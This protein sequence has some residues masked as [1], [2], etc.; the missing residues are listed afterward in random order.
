MLLN[1]LNQ[2]A[3]EW[4]TR[5]GACFPLPFLVL[6]PLFLMLSCYYYVPYLFPRLH[7]DFRREKESV[8]LIIAHLK[9]LIDAIQCSLMNH[10]P[11]ALLSMI[12]IEAPCDALTASSCPL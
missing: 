9:K 7:A 11:R 3:S 12:R 1:I 2:S 4:W 5:A 8:P 6:T 10:M